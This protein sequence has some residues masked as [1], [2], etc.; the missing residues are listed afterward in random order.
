MDPVYLSR[1]GFLPNARRSYDAEGL[2]V[3]WEAPAGLSRLTDDRLNNPDQLPVGFVKTLQYPDRRFNDGEGRVIPE[4]MGFTCAV[5]HTGQLN[6]NGTGIRVEGGSAMVDLGK[7]RTATG[8]AMALTYYLPL[9]FRRFATRVLGEGHTRTERSELKRQMRDLITRGRTLEAV[10]GE[11]GIYPTTEGFSRLDAV[12]R[13]GNFVLGEQISLAN[14]SVAD[15]PVNFPAIWDTP[16]FDWVQYNASF[17]L[18]IVR[19]AGEAMGVFAAVNFDDFDDPDSLFQSSL[20]LGNLYEMEALIRG[21]EPYAGLRAP[22]WPEDILDPVDREAAARGEELY[23]ENCQGCHR[24]PL[25]RP[26]ELLADSLWVTDEGRRYLITE[27]KEVHD[28]G[29]DPAAATNMAERTA[30]LGRLGEIA[31]GVPADATLPFVDALG[32]MIQAVVEKKYDS[33]GLSDSLRAVFSG[34]RS[35]AAAQALLV[36][37]ARPLNGVW[38]TPPYLHNGSVQNVYQLLAPEEERDSTFWLGTKEYDPD[39]LGYVSGPVDGGFVFDTGIPGNSN[40]GHN[41]T[42]GPDSWLQG[43]GIVGRALTHQERMDLIEFL[44]AMPAVPGGG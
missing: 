20:D 1:F 27:K 44:K 24:P 26:D 29:T 25:T 16:W 42:G 33:L 34:E 18:P 7:F 14:L 2:S 40:K 38:A 3:G 6:V 4:V 41:F 43:G 36:Y 9:R 23:V 8:Y 10:F 19:N 11:R 35:G 28:V 13:I 31:L 15:A 39:V 21:T 5:C 17:K 37:K 32:A 12:G 22:E 30:R